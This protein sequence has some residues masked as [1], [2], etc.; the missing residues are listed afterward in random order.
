MGKMPLLFVIAFVVV[1]SAGFLTGYFLERT[2]IVYTRSELDQ[3]KT[4]IENMQ[5]Q[6]IFISG[7]EV[8]CRLMYSAM[9]SLSYNL[10][11]MVNRLRNMTPETP[12]FYEI[13]READFLSLKAWLVSRNIR[14]KCTENI[15]PVLFM[16]SGE[17]PECEEQ[18]SNLQELKSRYDTVLVYAIDYNQEQPAIKL[19]KD[20]YHINSTPSMI[21]DYRVYGK[22]SL[23]ELEDI[24][25]GITEC[26]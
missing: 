11:D 12:E 18:D 7:E 8:D 10:Y 9:G 19:V 3:L 15:L 17:C 16:Y 13:K 14:I 26:A 2:S 5:L 6:E 20:A 23:Q 4:E 25:C 22:L 1:F 24:Y 21:I